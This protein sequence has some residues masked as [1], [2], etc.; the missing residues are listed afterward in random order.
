MWYQ[1][2]IGYFIWTSHVTGWN[3]N[4]AAVY[5]AESITSPTWTSL[6]NPTH[7]STSFRSQST[8][9]L[10]VNGSV[11]Y[12]ADRFEPYVGKGTSPRYVPHPPGDFLDRNPAP[13]SDVTFAV[14]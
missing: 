1:P 14:P 9:I 10:P 7:S 11:I 13:F 12:V 3:P 4:P 5:F 2:G 6:G 8:Y